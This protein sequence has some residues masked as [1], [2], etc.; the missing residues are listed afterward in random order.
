M[1]SAQPKFRFTIITQ[2]HMAQA[3]TLFPGLMLTVPAK[4]CHLIL[5]HNVSDQKIDSGT[6]KQVCSLIPW[7]PYT[8]W[9]DGMSTFFCTPIAL[10]HRISRPFLRFLPR[11]ILFL[12]FFSSLFHSAVSSKRWDVRKPEEKKKKPSLYD[13]ELTVNQERHRELWK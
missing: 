2:L 11:L 10:S 13:E 8:A 1:K 6:L 7:F 4:S 12:S 3:T 5:V 9:T